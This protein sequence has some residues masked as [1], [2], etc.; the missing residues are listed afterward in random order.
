MKSIVDK[1]NLAMIAATA[2]AV[3]WM[4]TT[5]ASASDVME[6]KVEIWYGQFYALM[7]EVEDAKAKGNEALANELIRR[8]ERLRA[9]ICA[10]DPEWER[11]KD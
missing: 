10:E 6:L 4:F 5:F 7:D 11:C 3:I 9:R 2:S 1:V 8:M